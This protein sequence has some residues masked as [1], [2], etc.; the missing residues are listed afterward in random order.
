MLQYHQ[1]KRFIK[2]KIK[3]IKLAVG[4]NLA[5]TALS[6]GVDSSVV[7]VLGHKALGEKLSVCFI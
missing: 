7:T 4:D 2:E 5:M 3:E 1:T 6:G